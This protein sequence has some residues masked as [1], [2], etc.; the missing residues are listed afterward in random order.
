MSNIAAI[1]TWDQTANAGRAARE[2]RQRGK[3]TF[4]NPGAFDSD[5]PR[6][7]EARRRLAIV[8]YASGLSGGM[9]SR[10]ELIGPA[11]SDRRSPIY[12]Q[13]PL[14][15]LSTLQRWM[16]RYHAAGNT[17]AG[18]IDCPSTGRTPK[19]IVG[20]VAT[21]L[22]RIVR[23]SGARYRLSGIEGRPKW[24]RLTEAVEGFCA[25]K[26]LPAP[27]KHGVRRFVQAMGPSETMLA[28]YG[29]KAARA[30]V[31]PKA[32]NPTACAH[33]LVF[34]DEGMIPTWI[35][36]WNDDSRR[37]VPARAWALF[38]IDAHSRAVL[39]FWI[40]KP[41]TSRTTRLLHTHATADEVIAL[42]ASIILPELAHPDFAC[43]ARG[44]PGELRMDGSGNT[45]AAA[46]RLADQRMNVTLGEPNVPWTRGI[47]E[48]Y[49]QTLKGRDLFDVLGEK[50]LYMPF[51]PD[52][53][54]PRAR[55]TRDNADKR[56][57][58]AYRL[59]VPVESLGTVEH[60][61]AAVLHAVNTYNETPHRGLKH[62][63]PRA[64]YEQ[65]APRPAS[66]A[67]RRSAILSLFMSHRIKVEPR[68]V[69]LQNEWYNCEALQRLY[70]GRP[71]LARRD[72]LERGCYI[73]P[74]MLA[75]RGRA[76]ALF[77]PTR[78]TWAQAMSP[79]DFAKAV[80]RDITERREPVNRA[81]DQVREQEVGVRAGTN[82]KA[83]IAEREQ[84]ATAR[85]RGSGPVITADGEDTTTTG[86]VL[87]AGKQRSR[88]RPRRASAPDGTKDLAPV[89]LR[90][91]RLAAQ[92][93][94]ADDAPADAERSG[95]MA[96]EAA[97]EN[98]SAVPA[99]PGATAPVARGAR[100]GRRASTPPRAEAGAR[101]PK[102]QSSPR[103]A[104]VK[105]RDAA[106][107]LDPLPADGWD[108]TKSR[109]RGQA[110]SLSQGSRGTDA[111]NH[112]RAPGS[113]PTRSPRPP[114]GPARDPFGDSGIGEQA[115]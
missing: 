59:E 19:E 46:R 39:G 35:R 9:P 100:R 103:S 98:G 76:D 49:F 53:E 12:R 1:N 14:P 62:R 42:T 82:V 38:L 6:L 7:V 89:D 31:A 25:G 64:V 27:S 47:I 26:E 15:S 97:I 11:L 4:P 84:R 65:S 34:L 106:M 29:S 101:R 104:L 77:V 55:R 73:Y 8:T 110:A 112:E 74:R 44:E 111:T 80:R 94:D 78:K 85:R 45:A 43:F 102:E 33:E 2:R 22:R 21:Y 28:E 51:D 60:L 83:E 92:Q 48:R 54:D 115:G 90:R 113:A 3:R 17:M 107:H 81:R 58:Q 61:T 56:R 79:R 57:M 52:A 16:R 93:A 87:T 96:A 37:W 67:G 24:E 88:P 41:D 13:G 91:Q 30:F 105:P 5:D 75:Q 50:G 32:V 71:V 69:E 10:W 66:D 86:R 108:E 40:K 20:S 95:S 99:P 114:R 63:R 70:L 72:P 23:G 68:G 109:A 36:V 18:L